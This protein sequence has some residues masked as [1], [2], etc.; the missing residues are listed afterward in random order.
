M[1]KEVLSDDIRLRNNV[2]VIIKIINKEDI[3]VLD[4][5]GV[6]FISRSFADELYSFIEKNNGVPTIINQSDIVSEMLSAVAKTHT[7]GRPEQTKIKV[8]K[9]DSK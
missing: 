5:A 7:Q 6:K 1:V 3:S 4:F 9:V 8:S 2:N